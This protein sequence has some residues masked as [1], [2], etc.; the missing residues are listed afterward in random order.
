MS[1]PKHSADEQ[2]A[3]DAYKT[4]T[5]QQKIDLIEKGPNPPG[6]KA[7]MIKKIKEENHMQ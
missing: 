2:K 6:A 3:I 1:I 7:A 4:M 5:P